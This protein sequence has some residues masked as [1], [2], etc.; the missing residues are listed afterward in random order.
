MSKGYLAMILHA[1]LPFVKHE[2]DGELAEDWLYEA[3]TETYI[4]LIII[5]NR[6]WKKGVDFH[7]TLNI[8]P[9]LA[10]MLADPT[11]QYRY[12]KHLES[13]IELSEKELVRT[14]NE[15]E[16]YRLAEMY[17][18]L[19]KEAYYFYHERY[20]NNLINAYKEFQEKGNIEI[21]TCAAT[22]AYLP[23][24]LTEEAVNAQIKTGVDTYKRFFGKRPDGIWLPECAFS[25]SLDP[26]LAENNIRYYIS[27]SH[28]VLYAKPRPRYGLFAPIY[29]PSGVAAFGRDL[30]SSKQVW[31]ANEGYPGDFN[32]REFYRDIGWDLD[33]EYIKDYLPSGIRKH[34][35]LKYYKI[36]GKSD[37]KEPYNP[38]VAKEKVAEHA[39]NFMFNRQEQLKYLSEVMDR[40]PLIVSPYDAELYGHWWFE[41]PMWLEF[42]FEKI[43]FDQNVIETITLGEY[44][45]KHPRNQVAMPSESSWGYKGYHE[46]WL[47]ET[48]DWIYRH[49][50]Q[51]ELKLIKLSEK[52]MHIEKKDN[53]YYRALNQMARELLL[54]QS[55]DWAFIMKADTMVDYAILRTK[56]H[57]K[58]FLNIEKQILNQNIDYQELSSLEN[59]N[60]LFPE[61]DFKIYGRR[62]EMAIRKEV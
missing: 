47:N 62:E 7:F 53:P 14:R 48:N 16:F 25:P 11:L 45:K 38:I 57:L 29:T 3:I 43:H 39:G 55:S 36:T 13:L 60:N 44:L 33:Y 27:S 20:K 54:A 50:H 12:Q 31:S 21:I 6:L 58:N 56:R 24:I 32:Y 26:I 59:I 28:G 52:Y 15:P 23:L 35:G 41:G 49:L 9:T 34:T 40:K 17:N 37:W 22:H 18:Y 1:H 5:M 46:V 19:F 30:E 61:I 2:K 8:S 10:S 51:A 4:P 42:L